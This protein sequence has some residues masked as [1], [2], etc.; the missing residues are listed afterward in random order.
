[1]VSSRIMKMVT[2]TPCWKPSSVEGDRRSREGSGRNDALMWYKDI[3]HH[4][5]GEFSM[6]II[7]A[8][9]L[10]E[11]MSQLESGPLR[12]HELGSRGTLV[13]VYDGQRGPRVT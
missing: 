9:A 12:S 1:M 7:Q 4:V 3:G 11:D 6:A 5:N 2:L 13:G 10:L 8:N